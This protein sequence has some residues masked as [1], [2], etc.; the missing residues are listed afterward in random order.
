MA[1]E[2]FFKKLFASFFGGS[3]PE[4]EKKR[5]L[6][7][8]GKQ[9]NKTKYKFYKASSG[10]VSASFAKYF[11]DIYKAV[12][13]GQVLFL[14]NKNPE[15]YKRWAIDYYLSEQQRQAID[16]IS[17]EKILESYKTQSFQ[18]VLAKVKENTEIIS[19]Y[20]TPEMVTKIDSLYSRLISFAAF[21]SY[22]YYFLLKKFASSIREREFSTTP[23]FDN[24]NAEYI[25]DDLKDFVA[26][27][28]GIKLDNMFWN[29]LFEMLKQN[30]GVS[31]IAPNTWN[32]ILTRLK[33]LRQSGVLEMLIQLCSSNPSY[34]I[35]ESQKMERIAEPFL[36]KLKDTTEKTIKKLE[37]QQTDGKKAQLISQ[38]FG[39]DTTSRLRYYTETNSIAYTKKN[40]SG[41]KYA[42]PLNFLKAFLIDYVKKD[43]REFCDLVL[44]RG[45]W[46]TTAMAAPLSDAYN[47]L[48]EASDIITDFDSKLS[49]DGEYGTKF[50]NYIIRVDRDVE[51]Q[52]VMTSLL[53]DVNSDAYELI[54]DS[55]KKLV[56]VGK[57]IKSLLEDHEK[58]RPELLINW[59][60]IERFAD[61]PIKNMGVALYKKIYLFVSLMQMYL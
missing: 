48:L 4:S 12:S 13:Q 57:H 31:P 46:A 11:Y 9:I 51:A 2:N 24:I 37:K 14:N 8:I 22:D 39:E 17:E 23:A 59:K 49:E 1:E 32:K 54:A 3:N 7:S 52:K 26:V 36:D 40:L 6:K 53:N 19:N 33:D 50:K 21:C 20:F 60:E 41:Y 34:K 5:L 44:V 43:L 47:S 55:G 58:P 27:A 56:L 38:I 61:Q 35:V 42:T 10:E 16:N 29:D 18:E 30:R 15:I 45:K 28:Y 25:T